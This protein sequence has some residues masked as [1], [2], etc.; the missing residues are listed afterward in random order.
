MET[1]GPKHGSLHPRSGTALENGAGLG[2]GEGEKHLLP[3]HGPPLYVESGEWP[4]AEAQR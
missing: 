2:V 1:R 4:G 3:A